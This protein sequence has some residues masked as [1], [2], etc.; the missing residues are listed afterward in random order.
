MSFED[1]Y[2]LLG[3]SPA[4]S[5]VEIRKAYR[6]LVLQFHPDRNP[7]N[8]AAE[9]Q[10]KKIAVAYETLSNTAKRLEY[11]VEF[12]AE[13]VIRNQSQARSSPRPDRARR[14]RA[15]ERFTAAKAQSNEMESRDVRQ[16]IAAG[17][18]LCTLFGT[19]LLHKNPGV[20]FATA[21]FWALTPLLGVPIGYRVG[22]GLLEL[23]NFSSLADEVPALEMLTGF[24][25]I[26]AALFG[27]WGVVRLS[28]HFGV[29]LLTLGLVPGALAAGFG[30][31]L[32]SAF[33]R[34]FT[35]VGEHWLGKLVGVCVGSLVAA[36]VGGALG[37][38][39][40]ALFS[41]FYGERIYDAFLNSVM[42]GSL[43][44]IL[45]SIFGSLREPNSD[46]RFSV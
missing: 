23:F 11:D 6:R 4:S 9:E 27:A 18:F 31:T 28:G 29:S 39:F 19:F 25:P 1:Y 21:F 15:D 45:A 43:G 33:G 40:A 38:F 14:R 2:S 12:Q 10:F 5:A 46:S 36:I 32:G 26:L 30:S 7:G 41:R 35:S 37:L 24:F 16:G 17:A 42:G 13:R 8:D 3:V 20:G 44:G 22:S 34:A